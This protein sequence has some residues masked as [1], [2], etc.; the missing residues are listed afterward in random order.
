MIITGCSAENDS[1]SK[2]EVGRGEQGEEGR[3]RGEENGASGE[4][5]RNCIQRQQAA[6]GR[7][8]GPEL[9]LVHSQ[10]TAN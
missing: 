7:L 1:T 6:T 5:L 3:R 8:N 4:D 9:D 2:R 10:R